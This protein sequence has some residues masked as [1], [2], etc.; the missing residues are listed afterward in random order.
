MPDLVFSVKRCDNAH[1]GTKLPLPLL[2]VQLLSPK[3]STIK[4]V[5]PDRNLPPALSDA[6]KP[7]S[8]RSPTNPSIYGV[9]YS[10]SITP[11]PRS[12]QR[13]SSRR[14]G[15]FKGPRARRQKRI[16]S[17]W[18][19]QGDL[20]C[21]SPKVLPLIGCALLYSQYYSGSNHYQSCKSC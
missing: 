19:A 6:P 16:W 7:H 21:S 9:T 13:H 8:A 20:D 14:L 3:K 11:S 12:G 5:A 10:N 1:Y 18:S 4:K 2:Y 17:L 15:G